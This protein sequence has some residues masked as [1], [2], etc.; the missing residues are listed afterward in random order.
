MAETSEVLLMGG[1]LK[2]VAMTDLDEGTLFKRS[3]TEQYVEACD[4]IADHPL[5]LIIHDV[6]AD[7]LLNQTGANAEW[8]LK[9]CV[10]KTPLDFDHAAGDLLQPGTDGTIDIFGAGTVIGVCME[11]GLAG[12][13]AKCQFF[14]T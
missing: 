12:T 1:S 10:I 6:E 2:A 8:F 13:Y 7:D 4:A 11:D 14:A 3:A 9:G 5:G